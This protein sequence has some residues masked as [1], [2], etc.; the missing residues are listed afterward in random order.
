MIGGQAIA[1][2]IVWTDPLKQCIQ[3]LPEGSCGPT[4]DQTWH[5]V[6]GNPPP[7]PG[8]DF[9]EPGAIFDHS[10]SCKNLLFG[11]YIFGG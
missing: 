5:R 2:D 1:H 7:P 11:G 4:N 9:R 3:K 8:P 10:L 6:S